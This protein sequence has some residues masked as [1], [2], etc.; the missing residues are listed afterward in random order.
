[1]FYFL[2]NKTYY[3]TLIFINHNIFDL[4]IKIIFPRL[5]DPVVS[6]NWCQLNGRT[7]SYALVSRRS[8]FRAGVR[9]FTRGIDSNGNVANFV[10]TEQIVE[11]STDLAS[12]VQVNIFD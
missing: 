4:S 3:Y 10:E 2:Q 9:L 5:S 1:M 12:F 6:I 7:F 8:R 11:T